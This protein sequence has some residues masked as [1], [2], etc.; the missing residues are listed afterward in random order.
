LGVFLLTLIWQSILTLPAQILFRRFHAFVICFLMAAWN[1]HIIISVCEK[2]TF[3][4]I[5]S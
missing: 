5:S 1:C 2:F 4:A 3:M